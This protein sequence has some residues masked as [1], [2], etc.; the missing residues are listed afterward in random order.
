[1]AAEAVVVDAADRGLAYGDG[2]FETIRTHRGTLPWWLRHR[3][4][5]ALGAARLGIAMP[6]D[7]RLDAV[8]TDALV[9]ADREFGG[10]AV[11]KLVLTRG[12][13]ARGY[14]PVDGIAPTLFA[15]ASPVPAAT[16]DPLIVDLLTLRLG[17]QPALAGI[18]HLNRLE[19]V[20]GAREANERG[21][22]DGLM[23]DADGFL[24]CSTRANL[25]ARIDG[26]WITPPV[27]HAGVAGVARGVLIE[28]WRPEGGLRV[29]RLP[30]AELGRVEALTLS[31]A[32]RGI[33]VVARCGA[34]PLDPLPDGLTEACAALAASHP[35]FL[36]S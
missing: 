34:R 36:E 7:A 29:E 19:Q 28:Q 30:L 11:I 35:A 10:E 5:L 21:L 9:R 26:R 15:T 23:A 17:V 25:F 31:N 4:R 6:D 33:L 27:D 22:D 24:T 16:P 12:A 13:G 14:A 32:V 1:M 8:L 2:L 3:A 20:L 18:K